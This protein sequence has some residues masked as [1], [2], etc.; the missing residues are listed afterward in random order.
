MHDMILAYLMKK[1]EI[2]KILYVNLLGKV[3][4]KGKVPL[5]S[6]FESHGFTLLD[7]I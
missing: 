1:Q 2:N 6:C 5:Q 3:L 7:P 4:Q